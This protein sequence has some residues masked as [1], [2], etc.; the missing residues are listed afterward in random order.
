[1]R[2]SPV[3][4]V[5][6]TSDPTTG[7]TSG[8]AAPPKHTRA[9]TSEDVAPAP[10]YTAPPQANSC[11]DAFS[12]V[13]PLGL[14]A[15]YWGVAADVEPSEDLTIRFTGV[16]VATDDHPPTEKDRFER[17][18]VVKPLPATGGRF[19]ATARIHGVASGEWKVSAHRLG[20]AE[21]TERPQRSVLT[22]RTAL[23]NHGPAVRLWSWPGLVA[24]GAVVAVILQGLL[25]SRTDT[26]VAAAV[27]ISAVSC[28]LGYVGAKAWYLI[29]HRQPVR[30][31]IRAGACIQGFLVVALSTLIV[32]GALGGMDVGTVVDATTPGLFLGMAIG[33][34]GC[35]LA[36]CCSGRPTRSRWGLFSS[37]RILATR[38]IPV[39]LYEAAAALLIAGVTLSVLLRVHLPVGGLLFVGSIAAYTL[40]RQGLFSFRVDTH[41]RRGRLAV[42][43]VCCAVLIGVAAGSQVLSR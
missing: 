16:R 2:T 7:T 23:L 36:G 20:G 3:R 8:T 39:Q 18:L 34:P 43:L 17:T 33:R 30:A 14:A 38:R 9:D 31:F 22:A 29:L 25:L 40:I 24:A 37:D 6:R 42:S 13:E 19:A 26:N 11:S 4:P 1:M 41:T 35:F 15:T 12:Q 10:Q 32:G 5:A 27:S 21:R 28:I